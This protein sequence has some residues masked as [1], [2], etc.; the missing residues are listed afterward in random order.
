MITIL[1]FIE[2]PIIPSNIQIILIVVILIESWVF[3]QF[4]KFFPLFL[5]LLK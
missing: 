4:K 1:S 2:F 3:R 5:I